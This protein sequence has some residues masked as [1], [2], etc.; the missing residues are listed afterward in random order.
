M[1]LFKCVLL[2]SFIQHTSKSAILG[3]SPIKTHPKYKET[4]NNTDFQQADIKV[5][6]FKE[7]E[8]NKASVRPSRNIFGYTKYTILIFQKNELI[9]QKTFRLNSFFLSENNQMIFDKK[10]HDNN[11]NKVLNF[12]FEL[13]T[14]KDL[15]NKNIEEPV[16]DAILYNEHGKLKLFPL[17]FHLYRYDLKLT[18]KLNIL[19][20]I[21]NHHNMMLVKNERIYNEGI[22]S[23]IVIQDVIIKL[24]NKNYAQNLYKTFLKIEIIYLINQNIFNEDS[25]LFF[26]EFDKL[27]EKS[28]EE[29]LEIK[30]NLEQKM[31]ETCKH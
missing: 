1:F 28:I 12:V 23:Y 18:N 5:I 13:I 22:F 9:F 15:Y 14:Q 7:E 26:I 11:E 21:L 20:K 2:M 10:K 19:P 3:F 24:P 29:L 30:H 17:N 25:S 8:F 31:R 4:L 27:S 16:S 6:I